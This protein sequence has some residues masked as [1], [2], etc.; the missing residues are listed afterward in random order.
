MTDHNAVPRPDL[1]LSD[2][3]ILAV[4]QYGAGPFGTQYLADLGAEV[5]K[6]ENHKTGGDVSRGVGPHLIENAD[7][8]IA[9]YFYHAIN[10]N[11]RSITLDLSTV[12]GQAVFHRLVATAD[13]VAHNLRGDVPAKLKIGYEHLKHIKADIVCAHLTAYGRDGPR[14]SWPGYDYLMQAEAGY[15]SVTGEPDGPPARM[16]L[17]VVDFMTGLLMAYSLVA[18]VLEARRTG[19]GRDL[20]V[21]LFDTALYNLSYLSTWYLNTG[22]MQGREPRSAHPV[23]VPCQLYKTSDGW[24]FLMCNKEKF[25]PILCEKIGHPEWIDDQR[26]RRFPD[27]LK[28]REVVTEYLDECLSRKTTEQW[29][30][31]FAGEVPAAP[32]LDVAQALDNPYVRERGLV[33]ETQ[34]PDGSPLKWLACPIDLPGSVKPNKP[35]SALGA[36]TDALLAE[37]GYGDAERKDLK[38]KGII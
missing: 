26:F 15:C 13:A 7:P 16:G 19:T 29:L 23:V 36:D 4:E 32:L 18:G 35:S 11:K 5:I 37:V 9:S 21:N 27:R 24:I 31:I 25:W 2:L 28:N 6:I 34:L 3:R 10:R 8:S 38:N 20:D 1:P 14:A 12:D 33:T 30:A 17:S 22:F